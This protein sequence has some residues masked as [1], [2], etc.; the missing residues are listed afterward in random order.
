MVAILMFNR[1]SGIRFTH[2]PSGG[3]V[4]VEQQTTNPAWDFQYLIPGYEVN[5]EY[6]FRARLAY[7]R[8]C[9]RAEILQEVA[10]WRRTLRD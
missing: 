1:T 7:R 10:A 6:R 9:S 8:R 3:G 2:S 5:R 4:N